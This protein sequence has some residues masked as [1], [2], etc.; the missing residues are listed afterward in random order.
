M[1]V[2]KKKYI[3][4]GFTPGDEWMVKLYYRDK[5]NILQTNDEFEEYKGPIVFY[6]GVPFGAENLSMDV[7]ETQRLYPI[8]KRSMKQNFVY[9]S[10]KRNYAKNNSNTIKNKTH[11]ITHLLNL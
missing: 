9:D 1:R 4:K 3:K 6:A 5:L 2:Y 8:E 10:L 7:E 11:H